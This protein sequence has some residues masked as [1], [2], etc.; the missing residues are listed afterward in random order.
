MRELHC[1]LLPSQRSST[2]GFPF[3]SS[4]RI[5]C[6]SLARIS[7]QR[8]S[9]LQPKNADNYDLLGQY[10]MWDAQDAFAA[11]EQFKEATRLDPYESRY[12]LHLAQAY[13]SRA[14]NANRRW[15]FVMPSA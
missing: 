9:R 11:R 8:A 14:K 3:A 2:Y 7:L 4:T 6:P 15:P 13:N 12:W 5:S 1:C 10:F